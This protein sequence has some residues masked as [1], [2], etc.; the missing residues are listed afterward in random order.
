MMDTPATLWKCPT[1]LPLN[2]EARQP[3]ASIGSISLPRALRSP[4]TLLV[5]TTT[6]VEGLC[7]GMAA[8]E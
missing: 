1:F 8:Q 4:P 5:E 3:T 2:T 7:S 6:Q